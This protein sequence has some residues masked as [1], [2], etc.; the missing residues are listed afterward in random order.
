[1]IVF[2]IAS[3]LKRHI[4]DGGGW[5][6]AVLTVHKHTVIWHDSVSEYLCA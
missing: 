6:V 3:F 5:E 4:R 2:C 1:M